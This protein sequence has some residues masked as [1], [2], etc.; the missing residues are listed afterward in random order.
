MIE[1]GSPR[2]LKTAPFV[3]ANSIRKPD[4]AAASKFAVRSFAA[5]RAGF[6]LREYARQQEASS[7]SGSAD[8]STE[9]TGIEPDSLSSID[10]NVDMSPSSIESS[11]SGI[12]I[13]ELDRRLAEAEQRGRDAGKAELVEALD[14][15]IA[16]L[17]AA[18]RAANDA[19]LELER[20]SIVPLAQASFH[21]ASE[22]ARQVLADKNGLQRYLESVTS[23]IQSNAD[24]PP[25]SAATAMLEVRM[26]PED[27]A[28]LE[29]SSVKPSSITL[30]ADPLVPRAGAIASSENKVIDDRF[31]NRARFA[32]EAVL[33]AAADLLREAPA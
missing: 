28:L 23:V 17:D 8:K 6:L 26:N 7:L 33:S 5:A 24:E 27:L 4:P 21:I 20:R 2:D 32:K 1:R 3:S 30:V 16:A 18:G 13:E 22:L 12:S 29:R 14:H 31:E 10:V 9:K 15:A 11:G 19:Q 25:P